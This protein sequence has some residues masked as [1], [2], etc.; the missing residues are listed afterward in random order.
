MPLYQTLRKPSRSSRFSRKAELSR[1]FRPFSVESFQPEETGEGPW[2]ERL[3]KASRFGHNLFR[4]GE[5]RNE[6]AGAPGVIQLNGDKKN[7]KR[8]R[9]EI[10]KSEGEEEL[11]PPKK[12][13]RRSEFPDKLS[14][15]LGV[16][17]TSY[18]AGQSRVF[19]K[20]RK[21]SPKTENPHG[22]SKNKIGKIFQDTENVVGPKSYSGLRNKQ[23]LRWM[24]TLAFHAL[25]KEEKDPREVQSALLDD[26]LY[27]ATN[28]KK[29]NQALENL[30]PKKD[31][32][33]LQVLQNLYESVR[34]EKLSSREKRHF[35]K[36]HKR[37]LNDKTSSKYKD[38]EEIRKAL[39][40]SLAIASGGDEGLHAERR[41]GLK[42]GKD[43]LPSKSVGGVK[44][45]CTNC[46]LSLYSG[47]KDVHPGPYWPSKSSNL[48]FEKFDKDPEGMAKELDEIPGTYS[49][50]VKRKGKNKN[51]VTFDYDTDSES[52]E[53]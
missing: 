32:T 36:L 38:Y 13:R 52:D 34:D 19:F 25:N 37:I 8:K 42:A 22:L 9:S 44:R 2:E 3:E 43:K 27:M 4:M 48:G 23:A 15:K 53:D 18:G 39:G 10:S 17:W 14:E 7:R 6:A 50:L 35:K 41:I 21:S 28:T 45:P 26:Q 24:S 29:G 1:A 11:E 51:T 46:Y 49:T 30:N 31:Q 20:T 16:D 33:G 47:E 12:K 40:G 5:T